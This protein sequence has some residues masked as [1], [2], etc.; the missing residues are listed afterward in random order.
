MNQEY[1]VTK[2]PERAPTHP[3]SIIQ[4]DVLPALK[5]SVTQAAKH[6]H[7]SR[8]ALHRIL[9]EKSSVTPDMALKLAK[10]CGNTPSFWL[11]LQQQWDLWYAEER[12]R[13]ELKGIPNHGNLFYA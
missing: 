3:G 6:L 13:E 10:F 11:R 1:L 12:L 9:A 4:G 8:Q 2:R 7:I 5:M